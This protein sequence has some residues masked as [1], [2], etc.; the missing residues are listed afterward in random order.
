MHFGSSSFYRRMLS[1]ALPVMAQLF[2]QNLVSL[3]DNFMVAGLGDIKMSGV[4]VAG[5]INFIIL[6]LVNGVL[7]AG[8]GIF[9]SQYKGAGD[10][11]GMRQVFSYKLIA[12]L[13]PAIAFTLFCATNPA[14]VLALMVRGNAAAQ[15]IIVQAA[16]YERV[17]AWTWIPFAVSVSISSSLRE[18]GEVHVPLIISVTATLV[19]T[20][21]NYILIY[22]HFGAPRLEV[23][24]AAVATIIAR[25]AEMIAFIVYVIVKKPDF[26]GTVRD[27]VSVQQK[28]AFTILA[29]S[30]MIAISEMSWV[31]SETVATALYNSR[32]GAEIVSG[33]AAGFTIANLFF[34]SLSGIYTAT[35]VVMGMTLGAGKLDSVR[36]QKVWITNGACVFGIFVML[37]GF[38]S[39]LFI[40]LVFANL[41]SAARAISRGVVFTMAAYMPLWCLLNAQFSISRTGGDTAMG[42]IVDLTANL[43]IFVPGMFLLTYFTT[44]GPV[45]MYAIVKLSDLE[46]VAVA[47]LWLRKEKW[48][49]NL[50]AENAVSA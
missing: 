4:N 20:I 48:L 22:G 33:M 32:G 47:S 46:K 43:L 21:G 23:T 12:T 50:A 16:T 11:G 45:A 6:V 29:K 44:L 28:L 10:K 24:G 39:T 41:S 34:V 3:I 36:A 8:G 27:I 30:A 49:H 2:I 18:T 1:I 15:E 40:P 31:L 42:A 19:N 25:T 17:L 38:A 7:C 13:V 14:P 35:G 26:V 37:L 5:Q 9:M